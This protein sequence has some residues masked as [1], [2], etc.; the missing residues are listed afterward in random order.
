MLIRVPSVL[1]SDKLGECRGL[2][3]NGPWV[4]GSA[5]AGSLAVH[6]KNNEEIDQRDP[7]AQRLGQIVVDA[8]MATA[9]FQAADLPVRISPPSFSRYAP[10]QAY[11]FHNDAAILEFSVSGARLLVR[12][13]LAATLFLNAPENYDGG[14][15]VVEDNF[16]LT[17][18]KLAA[19]DMVLYPASSLHRV[20]PVT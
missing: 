13:D 16:G 3:S 8:M 12:T 20:Q 15:L 14:E 5:S 17:K 19:G 7:V 10:G 9:L 6:V 4:N 1:N 18:V 11:G 2:L